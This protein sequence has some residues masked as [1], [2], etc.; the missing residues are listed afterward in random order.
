MLFLFKWR[1]CFKLPNK[2]SE[3]LLLVLKSR[4]ILKIVLVESFCLLFFGSVYL[5]SKTEFFWHML[6]GGKKWKCSE[7]TN[8]SSTESRTFLFVDILS[9]VSERGIG[10]NCSRNLY[11]LFLI[12]EFSY[13]MLHIWWQQC[14]GV[15]NRKKETK[16]ICL[17]SIQYREVIRLCWHCCHRSG[18][19]SNLENSTLIK[20]KK[21]KC[22][23]QV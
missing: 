4:W 8:L 22:R 17:P 2:Y 7:L 5:I 10:N 16:R 1:H 20:T 12:S 6:S 15:T 9:T 13:C 14:T 3:H 19:D 23:A 21:E 18:T 11:K